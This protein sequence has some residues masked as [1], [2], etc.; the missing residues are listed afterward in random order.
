[1]AEQRT[2]PY[3]VFNFN[4]D[5]EGP[6]KDLEQ[7]L[8]SVG[9][10]EC[11]GLESEISPIEYRDSL[12]PQGDGTG[13]YVR[14]LHG[15]ER[16]PNVVLRRGVTRSVALWKWRQ[17]V[18]DGDLS[19]SDDAKSWDKWSQVKANVTIKLCNEMHTPVRAWKLQDAWPCKLSG[20][21]LSART[22]EIAIETLELC[23]DRISLEKIES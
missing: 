5:F 21:V 15:M 16:Y 19:N 23:C 18:R 3:G 11:T 22:N 9:F 10:M 17:L 8:D 7:S 20:P 1:M 14:K 12:F 6:T 2:N 13:S 4:L